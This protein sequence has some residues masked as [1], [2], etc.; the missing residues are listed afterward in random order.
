MPQPPDWLSLVKFVTKYYISGCERPWSMY[1]EAATDTSKDIA[2]AFLSLS[3]TDIVKEFF[4][5]KGLR[6]KRHGRKGS[7]SRG[8]TGGI[9]DPNEMVAKSVRADLGLEPPKYRL[10][11]AVFYVVDDVFDRVTWTVAL[12]EMASDL[13]YSTLLGVLEADNSFCPQIA[14]LGRRCGF[15]VEGG[16]GPEWEPLNMLQEKFKVG[17]ISDNGFTCRVPEGQFV[18]TLGVKMRRSSGSGGLRIRIRT[19]DVPT[20][21][22]A[23]S[24]SVIAPF[25]TWTDLLC[26]GEVKGPVGLAW[27]VSVNG[28]FADTLVGDLVVLEIF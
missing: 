22:I 25:E 12:F 23:E 18:A 15:G 7:K 24:P 26:S 2:M 1:A 16:P 6:S 20:K 5:P 4:R 10:G 11:N 19:T 28:G 9:P 13:I 17:I 3:V 14:R 21:V 8:V 27:E